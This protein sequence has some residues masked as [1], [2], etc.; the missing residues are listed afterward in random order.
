M[1]RFYLVCAVIILLAAG[2][3]TPWTA[4]PIEAVTA[5]AAESPARYVDSIWNSKLLPAVL[6]GR[7][8][9]ARCSM[10]LQ[11]RRQTR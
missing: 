3:C 8:R 1:S 6:N 2:A 5:P 4:R 10:R 9:R 7:W 11:S